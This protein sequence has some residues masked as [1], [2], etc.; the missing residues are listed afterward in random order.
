M[1]QQN[2]R[3]THMSH[4]VI[5]LLKKSI[6]CI[7]IC[8]SLALPVNICNAADDPY[9]VLSPSYHKRTTTTAL[10]HSDNELVPLS[11]Q[12]CL[13][14]GLKNNIELQIDSYSPAISLGNVISAEAVFDAVMFTSGSYDSTD[15]ANLLSI[16]VDGVTTTTQ[17]GQI[18]EELPASPDSRIHEYNYQ[19]GLRK[20]LPTGATVEISENYRHYN[21]ITNGSFRYYSPLKEFTTTIQLTQPLLRNFGIDLNRASINA[22]RNRYQVSLQDFE[23][24]VIQTARTIETTYWELWRARLLVIIFEDFYNRVNENRKRLEKRQTFDVNITILKRNAALYHDAILTLATLKNQVNAAQDRLLIELNAPEYP[25]SN[26]I[27]ILTTDTASTSLHKIDRTQSLETALEY[28]PEVIA[29]SLQIDTAELAVGIAKNQT[30][31]TLNLLLSHNFNGG[32]RD[33][34]DAY[35]N[36]N[37]FDH[38]TYSVGLQAEFPLGNRAAQAELSVAKKQQLQQILNLESIKTQILTDVNISINNLNTRYSIIAASRDAAD[39]YADSFKSFIQKEDANAALTASFLNLKIDALERLA[40][41]QQSYANTVYEYNI[42]VLNF[43]RAQGTLL[44]YNNI[45]LA[46]LPVR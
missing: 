12:D 20:R 18:T 23:L 25:L 28:R 16:T 29:Q 35:D 34:G 37:N 38:Q 45:K 3:Q 44:R 8:I 46:E 15:Q 1:L 27:E 7:F 39:A 36:K 22:A 19:L 26:T 6:S 43:H 2:K 17:D 41:S 30:L 31:P 9:D 11:L 14:I 21:D 5:Q 24:S 40:R 42:S 10:L 13:R 33:R 4:C 32:S